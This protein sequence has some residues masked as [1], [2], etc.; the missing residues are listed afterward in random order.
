M[1]PV[2][3]N[4]LLHRFSESSIDIQSLTSND[5]NNLPNS[6]RT[7]RILFKSSHTDIPSIHLTG[8]EDRSLSSPTS[9][10][11]GANWMKLE[12][13]EEV[14]EPTS[15]GSSFELDKTAA[16]QLSS[17][18]NATM[19]N[20]RTRLENVQ[21]LDVRRKSSDTNT[22]HGGTLVDE[23]D[24]MSHILNSS[25]D[26]AHSLLTPTFYRRCN[27]DK[28]VSSS[29]ATVIEQ[30]D[31]N[32]DKSSNELDRGNSS[33]TGGAF[34]PI[35]NNSSQDDSTN[36]N[37]ETRNGNISPS[38]SAA[39]R[40]SLFGNTRRARAKQENDNVF[41]SNESAGTSIE[42]NHC[43]SKES[44]ICLR[45]RITPKTLDE[46]RRA[47]PNT[48]FRDFIKQLAAETAQLPANST[49]EALP[50]VVTDTYAI[51][52][53]QN[54]SVPSEKYAETSKNPTET[55]ENYTETS[56]NLSIFD[57]AWKHD[58]EIH[59]H[60]DEKVTETKPLALKKGYFSAAFNSLSNVF[61]KYND[62]KQSACADTIDG[63][64]GDKNR[65]SSP[66][67]HPA[68]EK[69]NTPSLFKLFNHHQLLS[70][71]SNS[72]FSSVATGLAT[73]EVDLDPVSER[74]QLLLRDSH[75]LDHKK[76]TSGNDFSD[77]S[78]ERH[79]PLGYTAT[80]SEVSSNDVQCQCSSSNTSSGK[81]KHNKNCLRVA[82]NRRSC[83]SSGI[84][85]DQQREIKCPLGKNCSLRHMNGQ[86]VYP[87]NNSE[88]NRL[89]VRSSD[90]SSNSIKASSGKDSPESSSVVQ[91][92]PLT[93]DHFDYLVQQII[94]IRGEIKE[95]F[96]Q[97]AVRAN[98]F[99]V[100]VADQI[101]EVP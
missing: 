101:D 97:S 39:Q 41:I 98:E 50:V 88:P 1:E 76:S 13:L 51:N 69:K 44:D 100:H 74:E 87:S 71:H 57:R 93:H 83:E 63:T 40:R 84:S 80:N 6:A 78:N 79:S 67:Q 59:P 43:D 24:K 95:E 48:S 18:V 33:T 54:P 62:S 96:E 20:V 25:L 82:T 56:E 10:S 16:N 34:K 91:R 9:T 55:F 46:I 11:S 65:L 23:E 42:P 3:S 29:V 49:P 8:D 81:R 12:T 85:E 22:S 99:K 45:T 72:A 89:A 31:Y 90:S 27:S 32:S 26:D 52:T 70:V 14:P 30:S 21:S 35:H 7:R 36:H 64:E 58:S 28:S 66:P 94:A 77:S 5:S 4:P 61:S 2:T 75:H 53:L 47:S 15:R 60:P 17:F 37:E 73:G 86:H 19:H 68:T 38:L 92:Q